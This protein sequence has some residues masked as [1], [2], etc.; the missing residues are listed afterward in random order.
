MTVEELTHIQRVTTRPYVARHGQGRPL[1]LMH[2]GPGLDHTYLRPGFDPLG[3]AV[4]LVYYDQHGN[5]RSARPA[6]WTAVTHASWVQE[7]EELRHDLGFEKFTLFGH[8][9]GGFLAQE[10]ALRFPDR[11]D[12]LILCSTAAALDYPDVAFA[13][14]QA[15]G[16]PGAFAA[17]GRALSGQLRDD[18]AVRAFLIAALSIYYHQ[19]PPGVH[20]LYEQMHLSADAFNHA[21]SHCLPH[22]RTLES[23]P[24]IQ[25]PTLIL[26]GRHDWIAPPEQAAERMH[27]LM[28]TAEWFIF[29]N[30]GHY[31]F[32]EEPESFRTRLREWLSRLD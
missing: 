15:H 11:L 5:G 4:E 32:L 14:A 29:E 2:G 23:L 27:K 7:L 9:Y 21:F 3:D 17:L 20:A 31:P 12:G 1:V 6:D 26:T 28:P 25:V 19:P 22:F 18:E 13:R 10:Y 16:T 8:S 30:S 24:Q